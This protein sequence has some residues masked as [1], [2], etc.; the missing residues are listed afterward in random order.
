MR[1]TLSTKLRASLR[2]RPNVMIIGAQK[3]GTTS[4]HWNLMRHPHVITARN[5]EPHFYDWN[6]NRGFDWYRRC[7]PLKTDLKFAQHTCA[8]CEATPDYLYYPFVPELI[9]RDYPDMRFIVLLRDPV[10][11]AV[12]NY[13]M[14][15][16][17]RKLPMAAADVLSEEL[18]FLKEADDEIDESFYDRCFYSWIQ[19]ENSTYAK[20]HRR[21]RGIPDPA[22]LQT[23]ETGYTMDFYLLRGLY[24]IQLEKWF[25]HF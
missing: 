13:E 8:V 18:K 21:T 4:F 16:S 15:K 19:N 12:S 6:Y 25:A 2:Y 14:E 5:K 23:A 10:N 22:L 7:Y 1:N 3:G 17:R 20:H 24:V 9:A 11:R